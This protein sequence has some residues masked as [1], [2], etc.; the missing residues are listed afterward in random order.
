MAKKDKKFEEEQPIVGRLKD[1]VDPDDPAPEMVEPIKKLTADLKK[2][3]LKMP[4]FEA[5]QLVQTYYALQEERKRAGLRRSRAEERGEPVHLVTHF[6]E[7]FWILE[8]QVQKALD[9]YSANHPL[10]EWLRSIPGIGPVLASGL[11]TYFQVE[12]K[13][14]DGNTRK[15]NVVGAWWAFAGISND[16]VWEKGQKRPYSEKAKTLCYKIGESFVKVKGK[17]TDVYGKLYTQRKAYEE[18]NNAEGKYAAEALKYA[19]RMP[20]D[21]PTQAHYKAGKLPQ[22][23]LHARC[24]RWVVKL[25]LSHYFEVAYKMKYGVE[26][27]KP[28]PISV[29]GHKDYIPPPLF[30]PDEEA[31]EKSE[32]GKKNKKKPPDEA[33]GAVVK[34]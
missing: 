13:D 12:D 4:L 25:F 2:M 27:P 34:A 14:K 20:K 11:L 10:G 7:Q 15:R 8:R 17:T 29:L 19:A 31:P 21:S 3:A 24:R 30:V 9:I 23:H 18:K 33:A 26:P 32:K 5:R 16:I 1:D 28:Y 22:H 6:E